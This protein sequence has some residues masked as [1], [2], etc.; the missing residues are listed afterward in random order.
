MN[1]SAGFQRQR[2]RPS[3]PLLVVIILL[4]IAALYG[5]ALGLAPDLTA[6]VQKQVVSAFTVTVT[7]PLPPPPENQPE[8]DEA[9]QGD[10]GKTAVAQAVT[11]PKPP[12]NLREEEQ[13]PQASSTGTATRSGAAEAGDGT[14]AAGSGTGTGSGNSGNGRGGVAVTK[15]VH[16]SGSIDNARD[17]PVPPGGRTARQGTEVL[18]RVTVGTDGRARGCTIYR[19]SPDAEA[20]RITCQLVETRLGFRPATDS[21]G[22][23]VAA[24][25]Y[26]RQRWF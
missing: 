5:L 19:P 24:P 9:A 22:N 13:R 2:R 7:T 16:I 17:F 12:R 6:S 18:V 1:G 14:G 8:P 20:D 4:H 11:Q 3:L 21:E 15:P 23:P 25:F 26:W 10:P